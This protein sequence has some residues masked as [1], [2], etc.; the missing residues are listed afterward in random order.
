M[1][2][3]KSPS[4]AVHYGGVDSTNTIIKGFIDSHPGVKYI[5]VNT[6]LYDKKTMLPDSALFKPD[7]LHL[8]SEGYDR[9]QK[10][11]KKYVE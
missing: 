2:I 4:R 3:K 5:D 6:V 1:S 9:W 11:L 7:M 10:A 8:K